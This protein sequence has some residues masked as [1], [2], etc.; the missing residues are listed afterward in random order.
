MLCLCRYMFDVVM[1]TIGFIKGF[2]CVNIN[3]IDV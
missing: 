3:L 2:V 1:F